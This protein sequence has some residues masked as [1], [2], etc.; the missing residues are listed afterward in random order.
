MM[1][2]TSYVLGGRA[3]EVVFNR[4]DL[5]GYI[6]NAVKVSNASPV[7]M[8]RFLEDAL[9]VDVDTLSELRG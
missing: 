7:L 4:D 3:M 5:L 9:E 2:R 1:A 8:D 6:R